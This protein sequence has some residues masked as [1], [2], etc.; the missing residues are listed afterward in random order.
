MADIEVLKK[1][2]EAGKRADAEAA[3]RKALEAGAAANELVEKALIPAMSEIGRKFQIGEAFVPEMLVA[4]KAMKASMEIIRP[5]LVGTGYK[6]IGKVII[7]TVRGDLHDIGKN[8]VKMM[9]EGAG[10]E[11]VDLGVNVAPEQFVEAVKQHSPN[12]VAMSALLTTTMLSMPETVKALSSSGLRGKV[13]VIIGGAPITDA[14]SREIGA[15]GY[16]P[17][18]FSAATLAKELVARS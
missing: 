8:L 7:G 1:A 18:A 5:K 14:F 15:D 13:K 10:F 4:A 6:P 2:I 11:V 9:M 16:R 12:V 17:D 3:T